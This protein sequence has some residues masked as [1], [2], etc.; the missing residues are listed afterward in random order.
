MSYVL[1]GAMENGLLVSMEQSILTSWRVFNY[2]RNPTHRSVSAFTPRRPPAPV[3]NQI[4]QL[5]E[6]PLQYYLPIYYTV[7]QMVSY[8]HLSCP[9]YV[10]HASPISLFDDPNNE[11]TDH[12]IIVDES[13]DHTVPCHAA[14]LQKMD[15]NNRMRCRCYLMPIYT[16]H[17]IVQYTP[18]TPFSSRC[19]QTIN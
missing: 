18:T 2:S 11:A 15:Y 4:I 12:R 5:L 9:P 3:P 14:M 1:R 13:T 6:Y 16:V 10:P 19:V 7:F 8:P 17:A